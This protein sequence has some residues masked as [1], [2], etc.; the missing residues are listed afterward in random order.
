LYSG[1]QLRLGSQ[2]IVEEFQNR[3]IA[4]VRDLRANLQ[5]SRHYAGLLV[6]DDGGV[7]LA[8]YG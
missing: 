4:Y 3:L 8:G 2:R 7:T 5:V 1:S 6:L